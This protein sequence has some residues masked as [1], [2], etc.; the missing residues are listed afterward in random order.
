[1]LSSGKVWHDLSLIIGF[2]GGTNS[3][4]H[5]NFTCTPYLPLILHKAN[6]EVD[7]LANQGISHHH[8]VVASLV[9]LLSAHFSIKPFSLLAIEGRKGKKKIENGMIHLVIRICA[10]GE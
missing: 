2:H 4:T 3:E 7:N 8:L 9:S 6:F 1:M 5:R 10:Q